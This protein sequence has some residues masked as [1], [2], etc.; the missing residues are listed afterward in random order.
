MPIPIQPAPALLVGLGA[1]IFLDLLRRSEEPAS[2]KDHI[3]LGVWQGVAL[4]YAVKNSNFGLLVAVAIA[5]KLLVEFNIYPDI[6]RC[7]TTV[8]GVV[9]GF[10]G[11]DLITQFIDSTFSRPIPPS[12]ERRRRKMSHSVPE[13]PSGVRADKKRQRLVQFRA[14]VQGGS[15]SEQHH[16]YNPVSDITSVDSNSDLIRA[17]ESMTPLEREVAA[18]RARASLADSERR[19]YREERKWAISEGNMD[20]A[21]QLKQQV[22]RYTTLMQSFHREADVKMLSGIQIP[23]LLTN[24]AVADG[25]RSSTSPTQERH[26]R[27]RR[28]SLGNGQASSTTR[29]PKPGPSRRNGTAAVATTSILRDPTR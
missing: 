8:I 20:R 1:R 11:T 22:K 19:R 12:S 25:R 13:P 10:L 4:H 17:K 29:D 23:T 21:T 15:E 5:G 27:I 24:G 28:S 18:L 6:N 7:A 9:L 16:K 14:S 3:L 2:V 26:P